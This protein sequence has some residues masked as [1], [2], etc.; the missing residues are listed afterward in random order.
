MKKIILSIFT[1]VLSITVF[2]QSYDLQF[3]VVGSDGANEGLHDVK[4]QMKASNSSFDLGIANLTFSYNTDGLYS[5]H[6]PDDGTKAA[7]IAT[8]HNFNSGGYNSMDL[9]EPQ[10]GILSLNINYDFENDGNG[11]TVSTGSWIDV[12]TIRFVIKDF[13]QTQNLT[14][15]D[16][17]SAGGLNPV[18]VYN[19]A[20]PAV[21]ISQGN[22]TGNNTPLPV[23]LSFFNVSLINENTASLKWQTLTE[24]NNSHFLI[25]RSYDGVNWEEVGRVEGNG[26]QLEA[27]DYAYIDKTIVNEMAV[28]NKVFYR[29]KQVDFDG[30][31][32]YSSIKTLN[33]EQTNV[34]SF[35]IYPNPAT[36]NEITLSNAGIYKIYDTAG[37]L[38]KEVGNTTS[39]DITD[40]EVGVYLIE[41]SNGNTTRLV[42]K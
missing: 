35:K 8:A 36:G 2:A 24:I 34:A 5:Q 42:R 28:K 14:W 16:D 12:A 26:N 11:T 32:E 9:T 29:L 6:A 23:E 25:H 40:L 27:I 31:F 37:K 22:V 4:I 1:L 15:Q 7:T 10:F 19:D 30:A 39:I 20:S 18:V 3:V 33:L 13:N 21:A 17:Q 41:D 38:L